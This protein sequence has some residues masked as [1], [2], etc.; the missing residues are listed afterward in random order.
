MVMGPTHAMSGAAVGLAVAQ[1]IPAEWGGVSSPSEVFVYAGI[2]AGAAL[3]PD[4][5][6]PQATVSRSFGPL[7]WGLSHAVENASQFFVNVTRGRRDKYCAN[8]HRTATHTLWF[9]LAMGLA[10]SALLVAFGK[11]AAIG[12]LFF[13]LGLAIRGLLPDWVDKRGWLVVS[14]ASMLLAILAW[15]WVPASGT[16]PVMASAV[17]A[18][19][20]THLAGDL[21][22]K[23][24]IPFFAPLL[25]WRGQ[26]WWNLRMPEPLRIRASGAMDKMLLGAFTLIVGVLSARTLGVDAAVLGVLEA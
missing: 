12:L 10:S 22:T 1:I 15:E 3:L 20:L 2:A 4:L 8:G 17:T 23:R 25:P 9:A 11:A 5:D 24:G 14:A 13:F 16:G 6:S 19:V 21:I 18:G 26:R 7:S